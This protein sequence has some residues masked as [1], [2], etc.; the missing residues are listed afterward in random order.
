LVYLCTTIEKC[1]HG[2]AIK[3]K[4]QDHSQAHPKCSPFHL[5]KSFIKGKLEVYNCKGEKALSFKESKYYLSTHDNTF[6]IAEVYT[7]VLLCYAGS[8]LIMQ[9]IQLD[10]GQLTFAKQDD[11]PFCISC[12][13]NNR[14]LIDLFNSDII[15]TP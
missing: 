12:D 1:L 7:F 6:D 9:Q 15:S 10:K 14:M 2:K 11:N 4:Q 3:C 13:S 5:A 8:H